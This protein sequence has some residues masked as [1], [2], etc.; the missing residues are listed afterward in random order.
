MKTRVWLPIASLAA[1]LLA[2]SGCAGPAAAPA[3]APAGGGQA[4]NQPKS[5]GIV[6]L[7]LPA[8]PQNLNPMFK[9]VNQQEIVLGGTYLPLLRLEMNEQAGYTGSKIL[10]FVADKWEMSADATQVTF[11]LRND[12]KWQ[13]SEEHTSELQSH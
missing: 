11:H 13:R 9:E 10:P 7:D 1:A 12:V 4:A 6:K 2:T 8:D 5:G 3:A